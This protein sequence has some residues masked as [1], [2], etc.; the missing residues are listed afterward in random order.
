MPV[1]P[2]EEPKP[3]V[4][5]RFSYVVELIMA[6]TL[7]T[8]RPSSLTGFDEAWQSRQRAL[9]PAS[10]LRYLEATAA[11]SCPTL[12]CIDFVTRLGEFDDPER[13]FDRVRSL[14]IE[15]FLYVLLNSDLPKELIAS[16]L[17]DP[18]S[19]ATQV[20][21]LSYFSR[22]DGPSLVSLF[23]DPAGFRERI[24]SFVASNRTEAFEARLR[25]FAPRYEERSKEIRSRLDRQD[26]LDLASELKRRS[27]PRWPYSSFVFVPSYF[28]GY[29]N[30]TSFD[31]RRF[32]YVF[33]VYPESHGANA[34]GEVIADRLRVLGDRTRMD[35]LRILV[36]GPSYGKELAARLGLTTATVSRHLDQLK[37]TGL[38]VE[39]KPDS[40]NV[41]LLR[42]DLSAVE[43]LFDATRRF[44]LVSPDD[45]PSRR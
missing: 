35:I 4:E 34:L 36:A 33:N 22:M 12:S 30:I 9:L 39:E 44:L 18:P 28:E 32:L 31:E 42:V 27:F 6:A 25:D 16:C 15:E 45:P 21:L 10:S 2:G 13:L 24:L 17:A 23:S 20:P 38:V 29:M 40:Q 5:V 41:K 37:S 19:A 1:T 7:V 11:Y 8:N 43:A 14:P 3:T 26:P